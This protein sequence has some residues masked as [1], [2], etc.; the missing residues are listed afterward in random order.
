MRTLEAWRP[1]QPVNM[2][3]ISSVLI[4]YNIELYFCIILLSIVKIES[5]SGNIII[6]YIIII[7]YDKSKLNLFIFD[8]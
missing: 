6:M 8:Y 7:L 5:N 1:F 3:E 4:F 2:T